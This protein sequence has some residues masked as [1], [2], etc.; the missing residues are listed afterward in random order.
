MSGL[1][2]GELVKLAN[3]PEVIFTIVQKNIDGS[4]NIEAQLSATQIMSYCD[5]AP[6]MLRKVRPLL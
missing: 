3:I 6:E 1:N 5:I 2:I 4:V